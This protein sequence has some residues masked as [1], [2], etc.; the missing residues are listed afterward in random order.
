MANVA[1]ASAKAILAKQKLDFELHVALIMRTDGMTK[2]KA[3]FTAWLEGPSGLEKRLV[4]A[5]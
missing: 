4:P 5:G 3:V 2:G 1:P